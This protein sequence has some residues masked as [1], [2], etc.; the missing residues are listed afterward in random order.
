M[1]QNMCA[2]LNSGLLCNNF[3][4][5]LNGLKFTLGELVFATQAQSHGCMDELFQHVARLFHAQKPAECKIIV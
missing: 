2:I 4:T 3:T 1:G 5:C